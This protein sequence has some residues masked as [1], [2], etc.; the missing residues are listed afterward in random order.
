MFTFFLAMGLV[1]LV[2]GGFGLF[3]I[4]AHLDLAGEMA[5][6]GNTVFGTFTLVG[7]LALVLLFVYNSEFE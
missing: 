4:N 1:F 5:V 7:L 2:S 6:I 3:Y